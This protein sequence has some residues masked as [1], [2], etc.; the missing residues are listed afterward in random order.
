M[1]AIPKLCPHVS[2]VFFG[3]VDMTHY[4]QQCSTVLYLYWYIYLVP[5]TTGVRYGKN[6]GMS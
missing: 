5:G 3:T 2:V 1:F 4:G 6:I